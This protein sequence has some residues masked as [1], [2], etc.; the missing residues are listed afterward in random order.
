MA[1][2]SNTSFA[3]RVRLKALSAPWTVFF[4]I[5]PPQSRTRDSLR[6]VLVC[7][8]CVAAFLIASRARYTK[9][10][11]LG[12]L[13]KYVLPSMTCNIT[14]RITMALPHAASAAVAAPQRR[15]E[16]AMQVSGPES[17][18]INF[19][20]SHRRA[21]VAHPTYNNS[22][23]GSLLPGSLH[24][25][26]FRLS[27]YQHIGCISRRRISAL[28]HHPLEHTDILIETGIVHVTLRIS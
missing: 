22:D 9:R 17:Q 27:G 12:R 2:L 3:A 1:E 13:E 6:P 20:G 23:P 7:M 24:S 5:P 14:A 8:R 26:S 21:I 11:W 15:Q 19:F 16:L 28:S 18:D 25:Q 10:Q 4:P